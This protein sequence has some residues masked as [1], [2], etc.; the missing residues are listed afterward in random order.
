MR[1][2]SAR[3]ILREMK[4]VAKNIRKKKIFCPHDKWAIRGP[5]ALTPAKAGTVTWI[6]SGKVIKYLDPSMLPSRTRQCVN[7]ALTNPLMLPSGTRQCCS[8]GPV[9]AAIRDLSMLPSGTHQCCPQGPVNAAL[10][11]PP[12]LPSGTRQCCPQGPANAALRDPSILPSGTRQCCPSGTRQSCP[13]GPVNAAPQGQ[14]NAALRDPSMLPSGTHQ[15]CPQGPAN[16]A[17]LARKT[18]YDLTP[19]FTAVYYW[20]STGKPLDHNHGMLYAH[21]HNCNYAFISI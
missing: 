12:M 3:W 20:H 8:Q 15:C 19:S 7:A 17:P 14:T 1:C 9:N 11:D 2:E 5:L 4:F 16:A 10:R 18:K 6:L 13:Q 21:I